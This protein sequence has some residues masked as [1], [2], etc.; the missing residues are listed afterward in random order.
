MPS[1]FSFLSALRCDRDRACVRL[2]IKPLPER[3]WC[4]CR[5]STI[6]NGSADLRQY[7]YYTG[8]AMST[9]SSNRS[10]LCS[11]QHRD[12]EVG[13]FFRQFPAV[14]LAQRKF[15]AGGRPWWLQNQEHPHPSRRSRR[16]PRLEANRPRLFRARRQL[17][18]RKR[19]S[20]WPCIPD[21]NARC[22]PIIMN[23]SGR[24]A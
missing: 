12:A 22:W 9:E 21:M 6:T 8:V 23:A 2:P 13:S 4:R 19:R 10:T 20:P 15:A 5:I 14:Q 18:D 16:P 3:A 17:S 24:K 1:G 11:H 7:L